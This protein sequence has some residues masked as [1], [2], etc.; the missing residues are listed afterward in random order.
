MVG[1]M[2]SPKTISF[3]DTPLLFRLLDEIRPL[4]EESV[5]PFKLFTFCTPRPLAYKH[6]PQTKSK[7]ES[8][9]KNKCEE[10]RKQTLQ[11]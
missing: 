9:K 5:V 10:K 8:M 11:K 4:L 7:K 6:R 3:L 1:L 2:T